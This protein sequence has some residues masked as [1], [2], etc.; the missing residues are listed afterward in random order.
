MG[1]GAENTG[2][3][4]AGPSENV[5]SLCCVRMAKWTVTSSK[6]IGVILLRFFNE[7]AAVKDICAYGRFTCIPLQCL[8]K[9]L[10]TLL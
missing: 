8:N 10:A 9:T 6:G 7:Y 1:R 3:E 4:N 2:P 5:A